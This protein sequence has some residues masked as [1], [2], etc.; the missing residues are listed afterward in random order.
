[1]ASAHRPALRGRSRWRA[2]TAPVRHLG[3]AYEVLFNGIE[4]ERYHSVEPTKPDG[5]TIFFCG[6]HEPRKGLEVLLEVAGVAS[7][8][9]FG[10]WVASDGP[11]TERLR[12]RFAG[13]PRIE[14]LGR[15]R[16]RRR[17]PACVE[18]RCSVR[19]RSGASPSVSCS[20][21]P[22]R[23][24]HHVVASDLPGYRRRVAGRRRRLLVAAGRSCR[25][26]RPRWPTVLADDDAAGELRRRPSGPSCSPMDRLA[27]LYI[28]RYELRAG[29]HG[30]GPAQ[31][32]APHGCP[33]VGRT[34]DA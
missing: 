19:R 1:M 30:A 5:P 26:G 33:V 23:P 32:L 10:C 21:R 34:A 11:D 31:D 3:G 14:W 24:A 27:A 4:I 18:R 20:S 17:S 25:P 16:R 13:D 8:A 15:R 2:A 29:R 9:R 6:R 22:W 7:A 12:S 28:E